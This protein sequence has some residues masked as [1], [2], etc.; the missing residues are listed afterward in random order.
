MDIKQAF[1][2][3]LK[4]LRKSKG[5][6]QEALA[7]DAGLDRSFLSKIERGINQP[8]LETI[9][10]LAKVLKCSASDIMKT[11]EEKYNT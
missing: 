11:T 7:L 10:S 9:F 3:T 8:S 5:F 1:A 4:E 6:S 2:L